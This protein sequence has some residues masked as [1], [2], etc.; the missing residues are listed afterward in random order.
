MK[1][2]DTFFL[3]EMKNPCHSAMSLCCLHVF[4]G[5]AKSYRRLQADTYFIKCMRKYYL[6][7][8]ILK[9]D[10]EERYLYT[11]QHKYPCR[12]D[13]SLTLYLI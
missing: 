4:T 7:Y 12:I 9:R 2:I 8:T 3:A 1:Y 10:R 13:T 5:P 6:Q 11:V